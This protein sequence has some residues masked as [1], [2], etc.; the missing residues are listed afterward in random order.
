MEQLQLAALLPS[1]NCRMRQVARSSSHS[2]ILL[3]RRGLGEPCRLAVSKMSLSQFASTPPAS[4]RLVRGSWVLVLAG[5]VA[6]ALVPLLPFCVVEPDL[7][8]I[9]SHRFRTASQILQ[10]V[11]CANPS[12][13]RL[14]WTVLLIN[15]ACSY[16]RISITQI[17]A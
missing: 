8:T 12:L 13:Y 16:Y 3:C 6:E 17:S 9:V 2:P 1:S 4:R 5:F 11:A 7:A 10:T 14:L 15:F